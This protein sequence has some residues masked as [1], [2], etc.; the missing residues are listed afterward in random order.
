[1]WWKPL[2][3][4]QNKT[5]QDPIEF[6]AWNNFVMNSQPADHDKASSK[7]AAA[8]AKTYMNG[9]NSGGINS[10]LTNYWEQSGAETLSAL[11]AIGASAAAEQFDKVLIGLGVPVPASTQGDRWELLEKYWLEDLIAHDTLTDEADK[12]LTRLLE[13]HVEE[14]KVFY[15]NFE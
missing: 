5:L 4:R 14:N 9:A 2:W 10:F 13:Q 12:E 1:M 15:L 11:K 6:D 8:L 3:A 7:Y